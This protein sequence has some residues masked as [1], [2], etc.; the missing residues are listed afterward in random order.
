MTFSE[1]NLVY[2]L[3]C[4]RLC[5]RPADCPG[6]YTFV[7]IVIVVSKVRANAHLIVRKRAKTPRPYV[8]PR[9]AV[10][11]RNDRVARSQLKRTYTFFKRCGKTVCIQTRIRSPT[12]RHLTVIHDHSGHKTYCLPLRT[13]TCVRTNTGYRRSG[14]SYTSTS[15]NSSRFCEKNKKS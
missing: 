4:L 9:N 10:K 7:V 1:E 13:Y 15:R 6:W 11:S 8:G 5:V 3:S 12:R 2:P 14:Q